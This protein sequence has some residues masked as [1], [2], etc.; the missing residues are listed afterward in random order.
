MVW[1]LIVHCQSIENQFIWSQITVLHL[2]RQSHHLDDSL[3]KWTAFLLKRLREWRREEE[4]TIRKCQRIPRFQIGWRW[5]EISEIVQIF[6][7][8]FRKEILGF[9]NRER[10]EMKPGQNERWTLGEEVRIVLIWQIRIHWEVSCQSIDIVHSKDFTEKRHCVICEFQSV[11]ETGY[12]HE[13][14]I[15]SCTRPSCTRTF[16]IWWHYFSLSWWHQRKLKS[17]KQGKDENWE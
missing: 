5:T 10:K 11:V 15:P 1:A 7:P 6:V 4:G 13:W 16:N 3:W 12:I 8:R 17:K 2:K 9:L 14:Q